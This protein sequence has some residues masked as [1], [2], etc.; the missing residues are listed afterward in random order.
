MSQVTCYACDG[1]GSRMYQLAKEEC[2]R[3]G[4]KRKHLPTGTG[5]YLVDSW[6]YVTG[7]GK[8]IGFKTIGGPCHVC[9]GDK[10]IFALDVRGL[11]ERPNSL[12]R[13]EANL[14]TTSIK[15]GAIDPAI[16]DFLLW[17]IES[18]DSRTSKLAAIIRGLLQRMEEQADLIA[19][20]RDRG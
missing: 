10:L 17:L 11:L 1:D 6:Y 9:K 5:G 15:G 14:I 4:G 8:E 13:E 18:N 2:V 19:E 7:D 16:N 12:S 3:T 20:R